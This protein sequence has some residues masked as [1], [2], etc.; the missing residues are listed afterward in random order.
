MEWIISG[1]INGSSIQE[2]RVTS[3]PYKVIMS[4]LFKLWFCLF[5]TLNLSIE[6]IAVLMISS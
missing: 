2:P 1:I 6:I 4:F 5:N 3:L